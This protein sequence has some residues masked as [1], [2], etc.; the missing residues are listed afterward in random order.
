MMTSALHDQRLKSGLGALLAIAC[1]V[2]AALQSYARDLRLPLRHRGGYA[3]L[4][5]LPSPAQAR[6]MSLGYTSVLADYYWVMALQYFTD[7]T[8]A[9]N[10][11]KN[12]GDYLDLV[13]G[14]DPDFQY[15]YKFAGVSLPYDEGRL[16]W[17]NTKRAT[18]F[19]ERGVR[20]FPG[21]W[22]MQF[23]LAY[24]YLNFH[25]RPTDAAEHF[26]AA[27]RIPGAPAYLSEFA[28]RVYATGGATE[29]AIDFA[30]HVI[31]NTSDPQVA[32][33]MKSRLRELLVEQELQRIEAA[34]R[35]F[36]EREGRFPKDLREL[37]SRGAFA[38]APPGFWL[39]AEGGAHP[40]KAVERLRVHSGT[41]TPRHFDTKD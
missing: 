22:Q 10:A 3:D 24:N 9:V 14:L 26:A 31:E 18:S 28:T 36:N 41:T 38:E 25:E 35:A 19:L 20:R 29:R 39:D 17:R 21:D 11:Y 23:Y 16:R 27:G 37:Y 15:A 33:A 7:S 2:G 30:K 6:V 1:F 12:L 8:Q 40:P 4:I 13:V 34:A 32:Q 5:Y